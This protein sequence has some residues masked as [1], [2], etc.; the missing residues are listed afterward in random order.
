MQAHGDH[1]PIRRVGCVIAHGDDFLRTELRKSQLT[2][3][4]ALSTPDTNGKANALI[5]RGWS[6]FSKAD[7]TICAHRAQ[8][9][10]FFGVPVGLVANPD[11]THFGVTSE[12]AVTRSQC[13][14]AEPSF[15]QSRRGWIRPE[16]A[17]SQSFGSGLN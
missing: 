1:A 3:E 13:G 17:L 7:F 14:S 2:T 8:Y 6:P 15:V 11:I 10:L 4:S 12:L 9:L 16:H 5:E